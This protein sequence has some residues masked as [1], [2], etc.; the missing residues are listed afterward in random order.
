MHTDMNTK[1]DDFVNLAKG[2]DCEIYPA[3]H[4]RISMDE[5]NEHYRLMNLANF[6]AAAQNF[7]DKQRVR[8]GPTSSTR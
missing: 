5:P 7:A 1:T 3:I 4:N 8:P 6:R 2:T